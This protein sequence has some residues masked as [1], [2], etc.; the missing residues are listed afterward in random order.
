MSIDQDCQEYLDSYYRNR[1]LVDVGDFIAGW[2]DCKEGHPATVETRAYVAGYGARYWHEQE[3]D[4]RTT[5]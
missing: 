2:T 4:R 1:P 5:V 3:E